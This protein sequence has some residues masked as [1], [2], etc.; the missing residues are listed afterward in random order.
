MEKKK[1]TSPIKAI[2]AYCLDC[3]NNQPKEIR[4]CPIVKCPLYDFR[5]GA[6]PFEK[7]K[8]TPEQKKK[9]AERLKK[10]REKTK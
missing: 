6:N 5:M 4:E 10:G 2:R 9:V 3:S 7:K 1:I 8:L